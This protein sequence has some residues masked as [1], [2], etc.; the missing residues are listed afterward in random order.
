MQEDA[1]I[2][3]RVR[4][5]HGC[6]YRAG[7]LTPYFAETLIA[8]LRRQRTAVEVVVDGRAASLIA[9]RDRLRILHTPYV[10]IVY[11]ER[12]ATGDAAA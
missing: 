9:L 4:G 2:R 6:L 10:R 1:M 11:R 3:I 8:D 7:H 5:A 12:V